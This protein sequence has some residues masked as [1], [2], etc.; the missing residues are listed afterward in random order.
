MTEGEAG[1][2]NIYQ[3]RMPVYLADEVLLIGNNN[4]EAVVLSATD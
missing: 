2:V 3:P 1:T 4:P